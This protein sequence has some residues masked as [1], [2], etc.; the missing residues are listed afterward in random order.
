M[1]LPDRYKSMDT[2]DEDE[3]DGTG[4]VGGLPQQSMYGMLA[5]TQSKA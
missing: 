3:D 4:A 1:E 2:E 5:A